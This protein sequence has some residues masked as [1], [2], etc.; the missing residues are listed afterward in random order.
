[1]QYLLYFAVFEAQQSVPISPAELVRVP[2]PADFYFVEPPT[3][4]V[5]IFHSAASVIGASVTTDDTSMT[6]SAGGR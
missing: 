3:I 1:M 5:R 4:P 2:P 6:S